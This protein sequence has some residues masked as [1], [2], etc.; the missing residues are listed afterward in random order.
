M[1]V[2]SSRRKR[3]KPKSTTK[4]KTKSSGKRA[5]L[6]EYIDDEAM[7]CNGESSDGSGTLEE[8]SFEDLAD[9]SDSTPPPLPSHGRTP[10]A[11]VS[12]KRV[13]RRHRVPSPAS[14]SSKEDATALVSNDSMYVAPSN[15]DPRALPPPVSTRHNKRRE[16]PDMDGMVGRSGRKR[17]RIS[18]DAA[19]PEEPQLTRAAVV[20]IVNDI[21]NKRGIA[22][23]AAVLPGHSEGSPDVADP[24]DFDSAE[25][26]QI[27]SDVAQAAGQSAPLNDPSV[28]GTHDSEH[29]PA[30][31]VQRF[32]A[33]PLDAASDMDDGVVRGS[34][35]VGKEPREVYVVGGTSSKA[36]NVSVSSA[37]GVF[38]Y[39]P[40]EN[41][42][43]EAALFVDEQ[44]VFFGDV[45]M[46]K[47]VDR[48]APCGVAD[49]YLQ[50]GVLK[51]SYRGLFPLPAGRLLLPSYKRQDDGFEYQLRGGRVAF[52]LWPTKVPPINHRR[53]NP[54]RFDP[55]RIT[56]QAILA[57]RSR[58]ALM[59]D[60]KVATCVSSMMS[61]QSFLRQGLAFGRARPVKTVAGL[62]HDQEYERFLSNGAAFFQTKPAA[63]GAGCGGSYQAIHNS[64]VVSSQRGRVVH[65][66]SSKT[67]LEFEDDGECLRILVVPV[68]D[69][70]STTVNFKT[71][72]SN[73]A[74]LPLF[75]GEIPFGSFVT[76]GYTVTGWNAIPPSSGDNMKRGHVGFNILWAIVMGVREMK[77]ANA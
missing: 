2:K 75:L 19:V 77:A 56:S 20:E 76:V 44:R 26:L 68:Y 8:S 62:L 32:M 67:A 73:I 74:D 43:L 12:G 52:S 71:G 70:R 40:G 22:V 25:A 53:I 50:D 28:H 60:G 21:L 6:K 31:G 66:S 34:A 42:H 39:R 51:S 18:L 14:V 46:F 9:L 48:G 5:L 16:S 24:I 35:G 36:G 15:L 1:P 30:V 3:V 23:E 4:G 63:V 38:E 47:P 54:S 13:Q 65:A 29:L 57:D 37:I 72:L 41:A 11:K 55:G 49:E 69:G 59:V 58:Y 64:G 33:A 27:M 45:A 10:K 17:V 61:V 7:E